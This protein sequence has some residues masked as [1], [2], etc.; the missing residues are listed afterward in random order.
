M[1]LVLNRL[2]T[3]F[4]TEASGLI[5]HP[6]LLSGPFAEFAATFPHETASAVARLRMDRLYAAFTALTIVPYGTPALVGHALDAHL[7]LAVSG[8]DKVFIAY[9]KGISP[10]QIT[11]NGGFRQLVNT[12]ERKLREGGQCAA[13]LWRLLQKGAPYP[14]SVR[15]VSSQLYRCTHD[16]ACGPIAVEI[17]R[18]S[19]LGVYPHVRSIAPPDVR[20]KLY[21]MTPSQTLDWFSSTGRSSHE[22]YC[23]VAE[24]VYAASQLSPLHW[25]WACLHP[26]HLEHGRFVSAA[27]D[28]IRQGKRPS[29]LPTTGSDHRSRGSVLDSCQQLLGGRKKLTVACQQILSPVEISTFYRNAICLSSESVFSALLAVG[30][31]TFS[32]LTASGTDSLLRREYSLLSERDKA[33]FQVIVHGITVRDAFTVVPLLKEVAE[34]QRQASIDRVGSTVYPVMVCRACG[35]WRSKAAVSGLSR[36]TIGVRIG[37]PVGTAIQCNACL[38]TWGICCVNMVGN[39]VRARPRIEADSTWVVLC[40]ACGIPTNNFTHVGVLPVCSVCKAR[41]DTFNTNR[42]CYICST[43]AGLQKFGAY[44]NGRAKSYLSCSMHFPRFS[45]FESCEIQKVRERV[46]AS[47]QTSRYIRTG[48]SSRHESEAST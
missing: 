9:R 6:L 19:L 32:G 38:Q 33:I 4:E 48:A 13:M 26:C 36:G 43:G 29:K 14:G 20:Q 41:P 28:M 17:L 12:V 2:R 44:K 25:Q 42:G 39:A 22:Y 15:Y 35:T 10:E 23:I 34:A 47:F 5:D 40:A 3:V 11:E 24:F 31:K 46:S 16:A 30:G 27:G 8:I 7:P 1:S 18:A 37:F 45:G 21:R